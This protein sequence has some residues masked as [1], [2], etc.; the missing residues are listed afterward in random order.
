MK[1]IEFKKLREEFLD[2]TI[3]LSDEKR[4]EYTEG[5][6]NENVLWNF[7]KIGETLGLLPMQVL[8][9][10]MQ[11]HISSVFNYLKDGKE[12]SESIESRISDLINY[13]L[14]LL[15]MIQTYKKKREG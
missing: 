11:K 8:S 15:C 3:K 12:Y 4:I 1:A 14:L 2:A 10:Y 13:L 5:H 6:H 7:E 9:V